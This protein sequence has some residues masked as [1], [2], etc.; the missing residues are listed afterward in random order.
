MAI[1]LGLLA[2]AI[3]AGAVFLMFQINGGPDSQGGR[4][5]LAIVALLL[6]GWVD[7]QFGRLVERRT[8]FSLTTTE[9]EG[10]RRYRMASLLLMLGSAV[11]LIGLACLLP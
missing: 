9:T 11:V 4:F 10:E 7:S 6:L 2:L 5:Y 1:F 3:L 8:P